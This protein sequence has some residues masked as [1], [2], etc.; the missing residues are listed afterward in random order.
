VALNIRTARY[1]SGRCGVFENAQ[2]LIGEILDRDCNVSE[3]IA[4]QDIDG[5]DSLQFVRL[6]V[7]IEQLVGRELTEEELERIN[8]FRDVEHLLIQA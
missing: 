5:W 2:R 3:N 4:L 1:D 8:N 7:R 6:V